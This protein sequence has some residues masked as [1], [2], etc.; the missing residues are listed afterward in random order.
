MAQLRC[1]KCQ[2]I[3]EIEDNSTP[4]S[5][6]TCTGCG[7]QMKVPAP[8]KAASGRR[9]PVVNNRMTPIFRQMANAKVVP[10]KAVIKPHTRDGRPEDMA[11]FIGIGIGALALV[12]I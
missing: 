8:P 1:P 6:V 12:I 3:F 2:T 4:G 5:P 10:G 7:V 9:A 11:K